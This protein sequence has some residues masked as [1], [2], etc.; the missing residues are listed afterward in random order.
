MDDNIE[1]IRHDIQK[2]LKRA[3]QKET[4]R[5]AALLGIGCG[6]DT[7]HVYPEHKCPR[8]GAIF[9]RN[10]CG[11]PDKAEGRKRSSELMLCPVCGCNANKTKSEEV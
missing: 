9:C 5:V 10:C 4:Y 11:N 3:F 8:C 7:Y 6:S 2:V 1:R